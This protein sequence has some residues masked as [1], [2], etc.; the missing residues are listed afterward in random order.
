MAVS[1][2]TPESWTPPTD[3]GPCPEELAG[4]AFL[5]LDAQRETEAIL[6]KE[7]HDASAHLYALSAVP[8]PQETGH[9]LYLDIRG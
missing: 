7:R 4:R 2:G 8:D 6:A 5:V 1:G 3:I 9:P